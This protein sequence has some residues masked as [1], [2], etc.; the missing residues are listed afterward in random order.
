MN[1]NAIPFTQYL[2]PDGRKRPMFFDTTPELYADAKQVIDKGYRFEAEI[3]STGEVS[4]TVYDPWEEEDI[5]IELCFNGP[6]IDY[7]VA[8]LVKNALDIIKR[9]IR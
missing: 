4:L 2:M 3:L 9:R 6:G 8:K 7:A 5:A 1:E